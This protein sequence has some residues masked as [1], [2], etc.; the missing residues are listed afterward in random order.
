MKSVIVFTVNS[1]ETIKNYVFCCFYIKIFKC[2]NVHHT[3]VYVRP[4]VT[5]AFFT[6]HCSD[7]GMNTVAPFTP[8]CSHIS[9]QNWKIN[10]HVKHWVCDKLNVL[11]ELV[12]RQFQVVSKVYKLQRKNLQSC[13]GLMQFTQCLYVSYGL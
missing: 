7:S 12:R 6:S 5:W 13:V 8:S 1:P 2:L 4:A 11:L 9:A 3:H 10:Y